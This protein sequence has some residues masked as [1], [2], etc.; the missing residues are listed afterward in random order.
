MQVYAVDDRH[1]FIRNFRYDGG[2]VGMPEAYFWVGNS[3]K[4][5]NKGNIVSLFLK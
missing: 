3:K 5:D 1:L 4:P 2:G